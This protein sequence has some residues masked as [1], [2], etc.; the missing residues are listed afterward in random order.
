MLVQ[1]LQKERKMPII[2]RG[3]P[4]QYYHTELNANK[5]ETPLVVSF[6]IKSRNPR[7]LV[8]EVS[9]ELLNLIS[10]S[11]LVITIQLSVSLT[12]TAWC[13]RGRR[14]PAP[15]RSRVAC[16]SRCGCPGTWRSHGA[17]PPSS[18]GCRS[19]P[20]EATES[21]VILMCLTSYW[22]HNSPCS[23]CAGCLTYP[24]GF[25]WGR[26]RLAVASERS[27]RIASCP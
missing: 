5:N 9:S 20:E 3:V 8:K 22:R 7:D 1:R 10:V 12:C 17:W 19:T 13:L 15:A 25:C 21:N 26:P 24:A 14:N 23:T 11:A 4:D 6:E 2:A 18:R 27:P 16:C